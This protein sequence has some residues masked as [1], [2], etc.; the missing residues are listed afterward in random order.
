MRV[1]TT[2]SPKGI[3]FLSELLKIKSKAI[4][5][6]NDMLFTMFNLEQFKIMLADEYLKAYNK[7][8][9]F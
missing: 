4:S 9:N 8:P 5:S 1:L 2:K 7:I 3:S 6:I